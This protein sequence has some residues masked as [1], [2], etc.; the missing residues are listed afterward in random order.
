MNRKKSAHVFGFIVT[1]LS[2][3]GLIA[4]D[5]LGIHPYTA[6]YSVEAKFFVFKARGN[7]RIELSHDDVTDVYTYESITE[8]KAGGK[9]R[10]R[11]STRFQIHNDQIL[12][13]S[14]RYVD[15]KRDSSADFDWDA[16]SAQSAYKGETVQFDLTTG[17]MDPMT[18]EIAVRKQFLNGETPTSY[19]VI[20]RNSLKNYQYEGLGE[21][22]LETAI[23]PLRTVKFKRQRP[24]SS[25]VN[26]MWFA[27]DLQYLLV[28]F[29]QQKDG[30]TKTTLLI[31]SVEG[32]SI[33]V[34]GRD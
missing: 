28:R 34:A 1:M 10:I 24:G 15:G 8:G 19:Q 22:Q 26:I 30:K 14:Y 7:A 11:Q 3:F 4:A 16:G 13:L 21:E 23:G 12:P 20:R 33:P 9:R 25:R 6:D 27:P 5:T 32:L 2:P 18:E 31:E 17:V 29:E